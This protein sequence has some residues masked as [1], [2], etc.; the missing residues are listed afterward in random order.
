M[1]LCC[2]RGYPNFQLLDPTKMCASNPNSRVLRQTDPRI[3][4]AIYFSL[5]GGLQQCPEEFDDDTLKYLSV[6]PYG[7]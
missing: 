3:L 6:G 4:I 1:S 5:N 2:E 7:L